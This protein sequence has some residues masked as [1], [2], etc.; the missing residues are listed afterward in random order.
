MPRHPPPPVLGQVPAGEAGCTAASLP[1]GFAD[2]DGGASGVRA[3]PAGGGGRRSPTELQ[4]SRGSASRFQAPG[5]G[6]A[7][8]HPGA[9]ECGGCIPTGPHP[10]SGVARQR[11]GEVKGPH[12]AQR[13]AVQRAEIKEMRIISSHSPG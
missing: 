12:C 9:P 3:A 2:P 8:T 13:Q 11:G 4:D 6:A 7:C 1:L 5:S 10:N